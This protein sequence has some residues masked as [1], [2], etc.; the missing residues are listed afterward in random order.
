MVFVTAVEGACRQ[1][2]LTLEV[3]GF[4]QAGLDADGR[5]ADTQGTAAHIGVCTADEVRLGHKKGDDMRLKCVRWKRDTDKGSKK[6]T[7]LD[8]KDRRKQRF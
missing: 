8:I 2:G 4:H 5:H 3:K 7:P 1:T 6:K